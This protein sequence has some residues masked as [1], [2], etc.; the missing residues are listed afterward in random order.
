MS[1]SI[2]NDRW[3]VAPED[4]AVRITIPDLKGYF[5]KIPLI[6]KTPKGRALVIEP[7][8]RALI[9]DDGVLLGEADPG[10]YTLESFEQRLQFWR[11]K[12]ATVFLTRG[13]DQVLKSTIS[14]VPCLEGVC[15]DFSFQWTLQMRDV[16]AFMNNL[17][18]ANDQ[19]AVLGM[20]NMLGPMV[21]QAI[22]E[23]VGQHPFDEVGKPGF[24]AVLADGIRSRIDVRLKRYGLVF[25]DLQWIK[26]SS[27]GDHLDEKKGELFLAAKET[28]LER[29]AAEVEN[30]KLK[31]RLDGYKEKI[32]VRTALREAVSGDKLSKVQST[33]DFKK[34]L[35]EVDQKRLLRKE[36]HDMLVE[37]YED[38]KEDR[39]QLRD[40]LIATL[41]LQREQEL[42][43]LRL[44]LDH[45]VQMK[46]MEH[47]IELA[48]LSRS[49]DAEAWKDELER[50]KQ[51]ATH[52]WE[53]KHEKERAKWQMIRE[54]RREK[55]DDSWESIQHEH[56][57]EDIR[58]DLEFT[59]AE[60]QRKLDLL[61]SE[62][63]T[64]LAAEKLEVQKRQKEWELDFKQQKSA[65]Q[66]ERLQK[67]QEM[68]ARF[69]EQQ[70]RMQ[71]ELETLK[72]DS[73]HQRELE[74]MQAMGSMSTE[75]MIAT[76]GTDNAALLADLKKHEA[77]Q[78]TA[79]A[80]AAASPDAA[81][82]EE[83]LRMYEKMNETEKAKADA[84]A[85]AY[86]MAM[87]SQQTNVS[88]MIGGLAQAATAGQTAAPQ[89]TRP[90][91]PK[92]Q[93]PAP[94]LA[95]WHVSL[96]GTQSPAMSF[97]QVQEA[98]QTGQVV[99]TTMVWKTGMKEWKTAEQVE[100]LENCFG[101]PAM[102][103]D[104]PPPMPPGPP[105]PP[106]A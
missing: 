64:R 95:V 2:Q 88:T 100:D 83:R 72:A 43:A 52:R 50:E 32:P 67:V 54:T 6:G 19:V 36:D 8:T 27:D 98:I 51:Q 34:A 24:T 68:N 77:T 16:L 103:N 15:Y 30:E 18:G 102:P 29:A 47:D 93:A 66:M 90:A 79:K 11:K 25:Q 9:F 49:G 33:E 60:R 75:A 63:K 89:P 37:A 7:G 99:P 65:N 46:S 20:Q 42:D 12:Q 74:R 86:K 58:G 94:N 45:V 97:E 4:Y 73:S 40:H 59:R 23:T 80:E 104:G 39:G 10:S 106:P 70:Q 35:V 5:D 81:L 61:D 41:D 3:A 85:E 82:N 38:K 56:K 26:P 14:N 31:A 71:L 57:M 92:P 53:Q 28:Q 44:D 13:E 22:R 96:N 91:A 48:K 1:V 69:A 78:E 76:A 87:Q 84:I 101:P 105:G 17:M 62:L 21:A 55:R